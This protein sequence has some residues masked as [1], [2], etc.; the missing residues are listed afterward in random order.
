MACLSG[1][2]ARNVI[3]TV[4][5][6]DESLMSSTQ[7]IDRKCRPNS[8]LLQHSCDRRLDRASPHQGSFS[9]VQASGF[10]LAQPAMRS[11]VA[12]LTDLPS[13]QGHHLLV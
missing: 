11:A 3:I 1:R 7:D 4:T 13:H 10:G 5:T 6:V 8:G 9:P 2:T 12:R